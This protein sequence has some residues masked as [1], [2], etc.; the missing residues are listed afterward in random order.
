MGKTSTPG[1]TATPFPC[2]ATQG[3]GSW[4]TRGTWSAF[5]LPG[6]GQNTRA[7][8]LLCQSRPSSR[9][10]KTR[11]GTLCACLEVLRPRPWMMAVKV[12]QRPIKLDLGEACGSARNRVS[13]Q[14]VKGGRGDSLV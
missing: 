2:L 3:L 11:Q 12:Y 8:L 10:L 6:L 5:F 9:T 7:A 14:G 1:H 4:I 13:G